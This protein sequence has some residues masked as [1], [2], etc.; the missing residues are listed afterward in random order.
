MVALLMVCISTGVYAKGSSTKIPF[1]PSD[2]WMGVYYKDFKIGYVHTTIHND[3]YEGKDALK[4]VD[5][6]AL[7]WCYN[8]KI[9]QCEVACTLIVDKSYNPLYE[10][11]KQRDGDPSKP[12][13]CPM[14]IKYRE[15]DMILSFNDGN[16][17]LTSDFEEKDKTIER[18]SHQ[19][20]LGA[21][22]LLVGSKFHMRHAYLIGCAVG[23]N[24]VDINY[25]RSS[26]VLNV[27][28]GEK[29][30]LDGHDYDTLVVSEIV[31]KGDTPEVL[32]WHLKTGEVV[33]IEI[34]A[35]QITYIRE[36]R[37]K[38]IL[39]PLFS[40]PDISEIAK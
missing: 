13:R 22:K 29:L 34:P 32:R 8:G 25:M 14:E 7:K 6:L 39:I 3:N 1:K 10:S 18:L 30:Q 11:V 33:K 37:E 24:A 2:T 28:R 12:S 17:L 40:G 31:E 35:N 16:K 19:Y 27:V 4:R 38:A 15:K 20:D 36:P 21:M 26:T 5:V 23:D 9:E